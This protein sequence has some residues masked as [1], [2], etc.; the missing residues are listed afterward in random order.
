ML[1]LPL[2]ASELPEKLRRFGDPS[3][4]EPA[5]TMAARGLLPVKGEDLVTLLVQ[6]CADPSETV[7]KTAR[8]TL[9]AIPEGVLSAACSAPLHERILDG[10]AEHVRERRARLEELAANRAASNATIARIASF[11]DEMTCER[12]AVDQE[13]LLS[14]PEIIEALYK[15]RHTRM[16]TVDRLVELAARN[17]VELTGVH[18]FAAHV[19]AIKDE[20][21]AEA[22]DEAL[23]GD[24]NFSEAVAADDDEDSV[25]TDEEKDAEKVKDKHMPLAQRIAEMKPQEKLR[26]ATL[27]DAAGRAIL[28]RDANRAVSM[29]AV[30]S[31]KMTENEAAR[32][33]SS[34]QVSEE[35]LR[36]IGNRREWLGNYEVKRALVFN[37]KTPIGV[38]LKF[39][40]HMRPND[41]RAIARSRNIPASLK[42][43]ATQRMN[44][45][46]GS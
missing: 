10:L 22:T 5:R 29:A 4:P 35:I 44:K 21:I 27:C 19:E 6:L 32:V 23:P 13:R 37:P 16:S 7:R 46:P 20:L 33:A 31:P 28:V 24:Q 2:P 15:N 3:A 41:L 38:S 34:K 30:T 25:E 8:E 17:G 42:A 9:H 36:Y 40:S 39:L 1:P 43:T 14:A 26:F 12:I 18:T 11:C 45:K